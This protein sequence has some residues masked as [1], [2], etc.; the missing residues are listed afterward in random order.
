MRIFDLKGVVLSLST[1]SINSMLNSIEMY[2][3]KTSGVDKLEKVELLRNIARRFGAV[4]S[5]AS[6]LLLCVGQCF[7]FYAARERLIR[8]WK[9]CHELP[10]PHGPWIR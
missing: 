2:K 3:G 7:Y 5:C 8:P 6:S 10:D 1:P 9:A 4:S